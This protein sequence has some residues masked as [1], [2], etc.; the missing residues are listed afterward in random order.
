MGLFKINII[1]LSLQVHVSRL[2]EQQDMVSA[3]NG[4]LTVRLQFV[5]DMLRIEV[6]NARNLKPMDSNGKRE[7]TDL[8]VHNPSLT[9]IL[10][11]VFKYIFL[12]KN[13]R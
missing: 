1:Y 4:L 9:L 7:H 6:M 13:I 2:K 5:H 8:I 12:K 3:T 10:K 11:K